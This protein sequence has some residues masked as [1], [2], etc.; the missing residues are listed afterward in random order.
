M[1]DV[2]IPDMVVKLRAANDGVDGDGF[3]AGEEVGADLVR[4]LRAETLSPAALNALVE[5]AGIGR[6][7]SGMLSEVACRVRDSR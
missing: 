3:A 2:S 7:V 4:C 5:D 1:A 6:G